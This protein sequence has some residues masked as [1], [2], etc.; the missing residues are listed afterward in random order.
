MQLKPSI[1]LAAIELTATSQTGDTATQTTDARK[2]RRANRATIKEPTR[3]TSHRKRQRM[4][5]LLVADAE[6]VTGLPPFTPVRRNP[7]TT[8]AKLREQM[9]ELVQKCPLDFAFAMIAQARIQRDQLSCVIGTT[10]R[11]MQ[12][13]APFHPHGVGDGF[14]A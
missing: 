5:T 7:A 2:I 13:R 8:G 11:T 6:I 9:R 14:A 12:P 3:A 4:A 1:E 10:G